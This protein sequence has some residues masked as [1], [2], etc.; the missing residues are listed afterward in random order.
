MAQRSHHL[1]A[2]RDIIAQMAPDSPQSILV[3]QEPLTTGPPSRLSFLASCAPQENT[4]RE[5][6][7][8]NQM[9]IVILGSTVLADHGVTVQETLELQTTLQQQVL[10]IHVTQTLNVS[11]R[12]GTK[13]Q[14]LILTR[15]TF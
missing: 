11:A 9:A 7:E 3:N 12:H 10:M 8:L 5:Q 13:Q 1:N 15:Q 14:V 2:Q 6:V 4:A